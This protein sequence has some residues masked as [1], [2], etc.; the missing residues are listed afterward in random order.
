MEWEVFVFLQVKC[1]RCGLMFEVLLREN[2]VG[3]QFTKC[4]LF[5]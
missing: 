5:C 3:N 1:E 4:E 2:L